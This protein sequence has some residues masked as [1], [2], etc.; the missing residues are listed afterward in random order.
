MNWYAIDFGTSNSLLSFVEEGKEPR[1]L[2][3]ENNQPILK[4]LIFTPEKDDYY[5]GAEAIEKYQEMG[6]DGRFFRSLKKFLAEPSFKGTEVFGKIF[7]FEE[8][9]AVILREIKKRADKETGLEVKNVVLGRPALYSLDIEKDQ[10]AEDRMRK[11]AELAGFENIEFCAEPIA[12]G[13]NSDNQTSNK[14]VLIC[15]FGG[16][17]SDFTLLRSNGNDFSK[18]DVYGLTGVFV[19]GDAIDGRIM[20]NFVSTHFGKDI[21]YKIPMGQNELTFP[22][23]LIGKLCNPAHIAFLKER[24]TWEF[25][26]ELEQWVLEGK[27]EQYISQLFCLVEEDLGYSVYSEIEKSKISLGSKDNSLFQFKHSDIDIEME[28]LRKDFEDAVIKEFNQIFD[29]LNTTLSQSNKEPGDVDEVWITGGTGQMPLIQ[30]KLIEIF[31]KE[32]IM[33]NEIYQSVVQG[34]GNYAKQLEINRD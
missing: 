17:T 3:L 20:R 16:G 23:Q 6:G 11:A 22:R 9:V 24:S 12:A 28:I 4:S 14:L 15:D 7:K 21:K 34:L 26:K 5:F 10:L 30:N 25:L 33:M 8:L 1:L 29:S 31:G 27:N 2:N 19:A 18:D 13:L 32:K